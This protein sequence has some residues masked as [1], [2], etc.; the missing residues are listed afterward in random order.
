MSNIAI[1]LDKGRVLRERMF[2]LGVREDDIIEKFIRSPRT[3]GQ[4]VNKV[5]TCVYL[6]HLPTN[7]EV[8]CRRERSHGQNRY[9]A[10]QILLNKIES[11][12]LGDLSEDTLGENSIIPFDYKGPLTQVKKGQ[13]IYIDDGNIA[14]MVEACEKKRLKARVIIPGLIKEHKGINMPYVQLNFKGLTPKDK[15]DIGFC[16]E[17]E[18]DYIAQSFVRN[19]DDILVL[20][21]EL[22]NCPRKCQIIAKIKN[23]EGIKNIDEII[24]VYDGIMIARGDMGGIYSYI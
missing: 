11:V 7:I 19:K 18:V 14:L 8:K 4:N 10:R 23:R 21:E 16:I 9:L 3:G 15:A 20:R 13:Y 24:K 12:I 5:S 2:R 1:G 22:E 6:R 17:N